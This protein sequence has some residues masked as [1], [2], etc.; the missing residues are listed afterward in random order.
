MDVTRAATKVQRLERGRQARS[1]KR[2][3]PPF[4]PHQR[5][6]LEDALSKAV[7]AAMCVP[8]ADGRLG[9]I[10]RHV[11]AQDEGRDL[12]EAPS[13]RK[14]K[15]T[16]DQAE[17]VQRL[18]AA[19][20]RAVNAA[21][22]KIGS[23]LRNVAE[24]LFSQ[25]RSSSGPKPEPMTV[26]ERARAARM[27]AMKGAAPKAVSQK[28]VLPSAPTDEEVARHEAALEAE[29][30]NDPLVLEARAA[31]T[32][33]FEKVDKAKK[34]E[35]GKD[36]LFLVLKALGHVPVRVIAAASSARLR[37]ALQASGCCQRAL[38]P[39]RA[40]HPLTADVPNFSPCARVAVC[41]GVRQGSTVEQQTKYLETE[42]AKADKDGSGT[43]D[44]DEFVSFYV[45]LVCQME[46]EEH[47]RDAFGRYDVD[48]GNEL[49]KNELFQVLL[50]LGVVLGDTKAE[51]EAFLERE[52]AAADA[53][54]GGTVDFEEFVAFYTSTKKKARSSGMKHEKAVAAARRDQRK[55][56][57]TS[58]LEADGLMALLRA[59][60]VRLLSAK[61]VL[62]R[63]GFEPQVVER[64]GRTFTKWTT[65]KRD[66]VPLL[67]R[68]LLEQQS[69][70]AFL[71]PDD[72][73]GLL[74]SFRAVLAKTKGAEKDGV[75][76]APVVVVSHCWAEREQPDPLGTTLRTFAAELGR[77][78]PTY[79]AWGYEDIG[80]FF[81]WSCCFQDT[82]DVVRTPAQA[83]SFGR[84]LEAMPMLYAHKQTTVLL[85][86]DQKVEPPRAGRGWP[87]YEECLTKLFKEA[88]P[89]KR[90][91]L[92]EAGPTHIWP[93]V[94]RVGGELTSDGAAFKAQGPPVAPTQF[95]S[96]M[97]SKVFTRDADRDAVLSD[98]RK[99]IEHGFSGLDRLKL[100]RRG[101][102]DADLE[103]FAISIKEVEC[104]MVVEVD[105]SAN[106][107]TAKGLEA[108]GNAIAAGAL[109]SLVSL[110]LS[111]CSGLLTLP[112][113]LGQL[114][115]LQVLKLDGC[116]GL[117]AFPPSFSQMAS[118]KTIHV[119]HCLK[120]LG[121]AEAL[122]AL[123]Q[124]V[125][126]VKEKKKS[127]ED[128][129]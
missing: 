13:V 102:S 29:Q 49:E 125:Q 117:T 36:H 84:A 1:L 2:L 66:P 45:D 52:F 68:Q 123:P 16:H 26:E 97:A 38:C 23:P 60:D 34:G 113:T 39:V 81:D 5:R 88:P 64:Q 46:A 41:C 100:S 33:T 76:A 96:A 105:L 98:Y 56:A 31:A 63:A 6:Q 83:A 28:F 69:P 21:N 73:D 24:H 61:W 120:L 121:N 65:A 43:V 47:A 110:N 3:G 14:G 111:D 124:S 12:P 9:F 99:T 37:R 80:V 119:T 7:Q 103:Q 32:R 91:R 15:L 86:A 90:Y 30:E 54:G 79:A 57:T 27:F 87:F 77:Q 19:V 40:H 53:D 8:E 67:P 4:T 22:C 109:H 122:A 42:F 104:P 108:L 72:L 74:A 89:P 51:K 48:G 17:E 116:I 44:F 58:F 25:H 106:D 82:V 93:K 115:M 128:K 78:M 75:D 107:M 59:G 18:I 101:W 129:A 35:I 94:L 50:E 114:H 55:L 10:A 11:V 92:P 95:L 112:D 118:L 126:I 71:S 62:K 70:E 127:K 20:N 85:I